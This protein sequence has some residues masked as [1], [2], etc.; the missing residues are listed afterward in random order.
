MRINVSFDQP[1]N[2]LPA[3]FVADVNAVAGFF[4]TQFTDNITFT[5]HVGFGEIDGDEEPEAHAAKAN[6]RLRRLRPS[7]CCRPPA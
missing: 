1:V 4:A 7:P 2:T 5:L 6:L 3:G